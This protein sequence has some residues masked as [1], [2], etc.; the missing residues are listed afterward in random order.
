MKI[1]RCKH[2][3][4]VITKLSD[5]NIDVL[6]CG[7]V[8]EELIANTVDA[9]LEKHIPVVK[10]NGNEIS[11]QVGEIMHPMSEDHY[12]EFIVIETE[13]GICVRKL[14]VSDNPEVNSYINSKVL[15]VYAY[16]N[17]HGLWKNIV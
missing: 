4:N 11:V 15:N 1:F 8:M 13:N 6:C 14:K 2:C 10:I 16:C 5:K 3:G 9:S 17:L 12:I 7:E